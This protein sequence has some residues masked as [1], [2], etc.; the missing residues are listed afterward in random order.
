MFVGSLVAETKKDG[1]IDVTQSY[2]KIINSIKEAE[3]AAKM[4]DKAANAAVEVHTHLVLHLF[5]PSSI[6]KLRKT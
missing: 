1:L 6:H 5:E 4:A 3:E 2:S